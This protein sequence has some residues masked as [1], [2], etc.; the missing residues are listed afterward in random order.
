MDRMDDLVDGFF[1]LAE[2][3]KPCSRQSEGIFSP[4]RFA[5]LGGSGSLE[6]LW[7]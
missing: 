7:G 4:S 1:S 6:R 2:L 3:L 5:G